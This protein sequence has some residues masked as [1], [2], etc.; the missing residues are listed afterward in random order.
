MNP[1]KQLQILVEATE[2]M[3]L[4]PPNEITQNGQ[5]MEDI[6]KAF[7]VQNIDGIINNIRNELAET[8]NTQPQQ[9]IG[10]DQLLNAYARREHDRVMESG[11]DW[12]PYITN[13]IKAKDSLK[14]KPMKVPS[15]SD[16]K[17]STVFNSVY[18]VGALE[19]NTT[20]DPTTLLSSIDYSPY[21]VNYAEYLS[22]PTLSEMCDRPLAIALKKFPEV[23]S[24]NDEFNS[25]VIKA[26]AKKKIKAVIKDAMFYSL[27]SP[28]GS[29]VVPI[30]RDDEVTFNVFNDT[31]FAY[32][33]GSSYSGI[34][35]PYS[36]IKVGDIYCMG[37]KLRHGVSAFFTC[38]G[39]EPLFGVGLNRLPQLRTA[40]EAWNLYVHVVK[41]LLVR[42]QTLIQKMEGDIQTDTMLAQMR[43]SLQRMSQSMGVSTPIEQ[44]R[45]MELDILNNNISPGTSDV[46]PVIQAF[47][48]SV[49]GISP[50]YFFG[51]GNATY[52][53][54]AFQI[55]S[56]NENIH[57]RYQVGQIEPLLR[58]IINTMIKYDKSLSTFG[59]EEDGFEIEFENLYD[60]TEQEAAEL[61][62]KKTEIL[63]RQGTYP[64]LEAA[65]KQEGLLAEDIILP[66]ITEPTDDEADELKDESKNSKLTHPLA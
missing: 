37:A 40:A 28:R 33:M 8:R 47:A 35:Q 36:Q 51:G 59:V 46:A 56:T 4:L 9:N 34:T 5:M 64:E 38:P 50:E 18:S 32:G 63:I 43:A 57:S 29:L 49:T 52:S 12:K 66:K 15:E 54:A 65:F 27:L 21:R 42:A 22:V 16:K 39:Y 62:A 1:L 17:F 45:G 7:S 44:A 11:K 61:I 20:K 25:A 6:K 24:E 48:S 2:K 31:Q 55:H 23:N 3:Y 60:E 58:F 53:Q 26:I 30:Q 13:I 19:I 14:D 41:Y 10:Q